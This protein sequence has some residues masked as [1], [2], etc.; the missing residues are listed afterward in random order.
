[1]A[2]FTRRTALKGL[3]ATALTPLAHGCAP[4]EQEPRVTPALLRERI[5][6]VVVLMLENRSFDHVFGS[7]SLHEGRDDVDG[8]RQNMANPA[9]DGTLHEIREVDVSCQADP[10]HGWDSS[11]RQ[12]NRGRNDGFVQA[13]ARSNGEAEGPRAMAYQRRA[14]QPIS[15][16]LAD[17]YTLCQRWFASV[18]GPTWPNRFYALAG[19]STGLTSNE[20]P[21]TEFP[22]IVDRIDLQRKHALTWS[23]YYGNIPFAGLL[24]RRQLD[25]PEYV[26][27]E[28]FFEHAEQGKLPSFSFLEPVYGKSSD[29]PPEHPMLGQLLIASIYQALAKSPQW[30]R[31]LF[32]VTY[33]EHGGFFDHVPPPR[34]DDDHAAQGFA[35]LGFRVP[36]LVVGPWVK[37]DHVSSVV[38]DHTSTLAFMERLWELDPLTRRD[39]A[40]A[41][42]STLLDEERLLQNKPAKPIELP[43]IEATEEELYADPACHG[44]NILHRQLGTF[45]TGMPE[46]EAF[47]DARPPHP[48]DRRAQSDVVQLRLMEIARQLGVW[49]PK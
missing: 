6:T 29:H 40:A 12:W 47:Y 28:K 41:E 9:E 39:A 46:L 30:E 18:M 13:H 2:R 19:T 42:L 8:L 36:T 33:D 14:Q 21:T 37:Q 1:M 15:Y 11:H 5:D 44:F 22:T 16:A 38:F 4:P 23:D 20:F 34:T 3:T 25:D 24:P 17:S 32:V 49:R 48:K 35:Q 7:L 43:V 27:L 10:P 31:C 26:E 45:A